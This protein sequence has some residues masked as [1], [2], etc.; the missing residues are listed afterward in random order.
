[1]SARQTL[2]QWTEALVASDPLDIASGEV[3]SINPVQNDTGS[4]NIGTGALDF[5]VKIFL[6]GDGSNVLFDSGAKKVTF[7]GVTLNTNTAL[8][9][10]GNTTFTGNVS[11]RR[12]MTI[13]SLGRVIR[14]Q[15]TVNAAQINTNS[16]YYGGT[17]LV[18]KADG[19]SAVQL[20]TPAAGLAG[21]FLRIVSLTNQSHVVNCATDDKLITLNNATADS[22][23]CDQ[24]GEKI[25]ACVEVECTGTAWIVRPIIGTWTITDA[26]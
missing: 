6:G 17:L 11:L 21:E 3:V 19:A 26:A 16:T 5:D 2:R 18:S 1:M 12:P 7:S 13:A 10:S 25:G 22:V 14:K 24:A 4:I 15:A 23:S 8:N 9:I 20:E